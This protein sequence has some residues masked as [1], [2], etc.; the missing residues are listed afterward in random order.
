MDDKGSILAQILI[1]FII[2]SIIGTSSLKL[3]HTTSNELASEILRT[4]LESETSKAVAAIYSAT[5]NSPDIFGASFHRWRS[6][7]ERLPKYIQ[8]EIIKIS[9]QHSLKSNSA[10]LE[11]LELRPLFLFKQVNKPDFFHGN[12]LSGQINTLRSNF[13]IGVSPHGIFRLS[14]SPSL[15]WISHDLWSINIKK[16]HSLEKVLYEA[17][18]TESTTDE[19]EKKSLYA[20]LPLVDHFLIYV[21]RSNELRRFSLIKNE[22]QAITLHA[23]KIDRINE[24]CVLIGERRHL[25]VEHEFP[26]YSREFNSF[27]IM[28]LLDLG[29]TS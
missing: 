12:I 3:I 10:F 17:D 2:I 20:I 9:S 11:S 29:S 6:T 19:D 21:S 23:E 27:L 24:S 28:D 15:A 16:A 1:S 26:C 13:I 4:E 14:T 8:N 22:N 25:T 7:N 18:S 5:H